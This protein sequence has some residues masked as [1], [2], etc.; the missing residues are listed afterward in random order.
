MS[1]EPRYAAADDISQLSNL[2]GVNGTIANYKD[3]TDPSYIGPGY[4]ILIHKRA[5]DADTVEKQL[6]FIE[7]VKNA[8]YT[9]PCST[10]RIHCTE[11]I[12]EF[13]PQPYVG[14]LIRDEH[15][16]EQ[17]WGMFI[18]AWQFHNAVNKLTKKPQMEFITAL[19]LHSKLPEVCGPG[20]AQSERNNGESYVPAVYAS[21]PMEIPT[22][23]LAEIREVKRSN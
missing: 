9:F 15:D 12:K 23:N 8:C 14:K 2:A 7:F 13:D 4:W 22:M 3:S 18:W 1:V 10:C 16:Q 11:Y 17:M 6:Q 19:D 5:Y 21:F 20:C